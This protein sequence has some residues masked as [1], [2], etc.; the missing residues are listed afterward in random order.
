MGCSSGPDIIQDGLVLC[1]DAAS[2]RS[3]PKSGTT[4]SDLAE[5]RSGTMTN[6]LSFDAANAGTILFDGSDEK[7]VLSCPPVKYTNWQK[8]SYNC[9]F[10]HIGKI[11]QNTSIGRQYIVDFRHDGELAGFGVY[12]DGL[13]SQS[14]E[15]T[16]FF[17][18]TNSS[19]SF[20]ESTVYSYNNFGEWINH[21][22]TVD[23]TASSNHVKDYINGELVYTRSMSFSTATEGG[24][25]ITIGDYSRTNSGFLFNGY[26]SLLTVNTG[27]IF[28]PEQ[29]RQNYLSTK[30]RFA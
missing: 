23:K 21:S 7:V 27:I 11:G 20:D 19:G 13:S 17:K 15:L 18:T 25:N 12:V 14:Q 30:E 28:T 24:N 26:I 6:G 29:V 16:S 4:W 9:W 5:N 2:I 22:F 3:Y 10:K 8:F 1:L